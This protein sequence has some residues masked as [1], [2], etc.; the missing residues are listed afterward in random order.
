MRFRLFSGL[1]ASLLVASSTARAGGGAF[2]GAG[3]LVISDDQPL[4]G[5]A[6]SAPLTP[7][8]PSSISAASFE[9]ATVSD[10]GGSGTAFALSP[11]LDYFVINGLSLGLNFLVGV[12]NP[13]HPDNASSVNE[14]IFGIA[15]RIGYNLPISDTVSFWPKVYFGYITYSAS[16][17]GP[18]SVSS[19]GDQTGI[20]LL[21][22]KSVV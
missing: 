15:P 3:Q 16:G 12:L 14:T 19:G 22:R 4:V 1:A 2:G 13:A 18:V 5:T 11:S 7:A 6:A 8:P 21:D 9:F 17:S 20:G 10:N